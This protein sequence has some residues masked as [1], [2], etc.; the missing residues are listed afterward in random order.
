MDLEGSIKKMYIHLI[1]LKLDISINKLL[2]IQLGFQIKAL[3]FQEA[4]PK[5]KMSL[6]GL[7]LNMAQN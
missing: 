7:L 2:K 1:N 4:R 6:T 3:D 5:I